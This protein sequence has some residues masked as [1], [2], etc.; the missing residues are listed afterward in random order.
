[1]DVEFTQASLSSSGSASSRNS[2]SS[3]SSS[4][5]MTATSAAK[6]ASVRP[7]GHWATAFRIAN[8]TRQSKAAGPSAWCPG[9]RSRAEAS[10]RLSRPNAHDICPIPMLEI[11]G[12]QPPRPVKAGEDSSK[13]MVLSDRAKVQT[14]PIAACNS[15]GPF[16]LQRPKVQ[17][18]SLCILRP[19]AEASAAGGDTSLQQTHC[20]TSS[21]LRR[22][23]DSSRRK[24]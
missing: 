2:V 9:R 20:L 24:P 7:K 17:T 10:A 6:P 21:I 22:R 12:Q 19:P 16:N 11:S 3:T 15:S 18:S 23:T 14:P 13:M 1:M 8:L 5:F 4:E